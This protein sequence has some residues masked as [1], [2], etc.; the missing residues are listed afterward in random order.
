[1]KKLE[2]IMA[3]CD[4]SLYSRQVISYAARLA[5]QLDAAL[6]IANVIN[7]RQIS[8]LAESANKNAVLGG[9][10]PVSID[11]FIDNTRKERAVQIKHLVDALKCEHLY[12]KKV[13]KTGVPHQALIAI[14]REEKADLIVMGTKG[15][16]NLAEVLF[17]STAEKMFRL[18]PVPLLSVPLEAKADSGD[19]ET[20]KDTG[21]RE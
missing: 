13:F 8:T 15:R 14:A 1:M 16:T 7:Q 12:I 4:L 20:D 5:D 9:K 21:I 17:G 10:P 19:T 2:T 3:A 6:I 11:A 18:C